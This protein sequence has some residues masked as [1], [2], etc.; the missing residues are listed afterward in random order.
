MNKTGIS[1]PTTPATSPGVVTQ[2]SSRRREGAVDPASFKAV[3]SPQ[4][5]ALLGQLCEAVEQLPEIDATRVVQMHQRL[6][7]SEYKVDTER[8]AERLLGL[9]AA[10]SKLDSEYHDS[11]D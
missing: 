5:D 6:L 2:F 8:L 7:D 1:K 10:L 3:L 4:D 9:E 11:H